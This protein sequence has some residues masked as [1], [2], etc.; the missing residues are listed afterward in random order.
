MN[1]EYNKIYK[2]LITDLST[3]VIIDYDMQSKN[4][5]Y[6]PFSHY[7]SSSALDDLYELIINNVIFYAYT[8]EEIISQFNIGMLDDLK[9]AA[10]Y[11]F[12]Q[13]LPKRTN[14]NSDGTIGEVLLDLLIQ[15]FEPSAQKLVARAKHTEVGKRKN[16]ITGY[17]AL[18]FT[19]TNGE[20]TLWLGQ[21]KAGAEK[22]C[23]GD[24]KKDLNTKFVQNYFADTAFYIADKS[25]SKE[26]TQL[27]NEINRICFQAQ[28]NRWDNAIK[29][30]KLY[31]LLQSKNVEIKIPCLLAYSN[32][33][34]YNS[35]DLQ[36]AINSV[37]TDIQ[38]YY[39]KQTFN[40]AIKLPY[41]IRFYIFPI[42]NVSYIRQKIVEF[43]KEVT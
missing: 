2:E 28:K 30:K 25:D 37:V 39:E 23:K 33:T 5:K 32:D 19:S 20:L 26:L 27:L 14:P 7:A 10:K 15:V 18:Y 34:V 22:Y 6:K 40:I 29:N 36:S 12:S 42:K 16:E 1:A 4:Y 3:G 41:D 24:I 11:A 21:A 38:K 31:E 43:K 13:R 8:E 9:V 17:D 35:K